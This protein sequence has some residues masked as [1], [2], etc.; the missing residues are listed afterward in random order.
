MA[1]EIYPNQDICNI[2]GSS[3]VEVE[4]L[5]VQNGYITV[6]N[7]HVPLSNILYVKNIG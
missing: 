2:I 1:F 5:E 4:T 6:G 7:F 3:M